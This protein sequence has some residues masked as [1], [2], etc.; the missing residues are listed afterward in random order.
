MK[1]N[2]R[3]LHDYCFAAYLP[4]PNPTIMAHAKN[5][6]NADHK[7]AVNWLITKFECN[8]SLVEEA[9][10]LERATLIGKCWDEY[11]DVSRQ[12]HNYE[13][14]HIWINTVHIDEPSW[15]W[16][17]NYTVDIFPGALLGKLAFLVCSKP[18]G[19]R[20]AE[21]NWKNSRW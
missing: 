9:R 18:S 19:I 20:N 17:Q 5:H 6:M 8:C 4:Y 12:E 2:K 3:L 14:E 15:R 11:F 13:Q 16:H 21:I 10:K 7:A 1:R